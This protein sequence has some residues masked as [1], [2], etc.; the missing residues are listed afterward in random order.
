MT[1]E[2]LFERACE[3]LENAYVPYSHFRVGACILTES[4][5]TFKGCNFENAS[6]GA[7][8]CAERCAP[9]RPASGALRR[10]QSLPSGPLRGRAGSAARCCVNSAICP[11]R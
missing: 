4:G 7:A 11:C 8:I 6:Y 5:E 9:S 1:H 2:Q 3:A 10:S